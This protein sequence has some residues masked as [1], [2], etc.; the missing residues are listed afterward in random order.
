MCVL[1]MGGGSGLTG[2]DQQ[3]KL[4]VETSHIHNYEIPKLQKHY[5]SAVYRRCETTIAT[6]LLYIR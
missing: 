2:A 5:L 3:I 1:G 4:N 6:D